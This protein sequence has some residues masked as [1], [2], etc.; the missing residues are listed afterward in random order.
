ME[1]CE[2]QTTHGPAH[3]ATSVGGLSACGT[4]TVGYLTSSPWPPLGET[5]PDCIDLVPPDLDETDVHVYLDYAD[6]EFPER[7]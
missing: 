1:V 6:R 3:A 5:C 7:S 4:I 2:L